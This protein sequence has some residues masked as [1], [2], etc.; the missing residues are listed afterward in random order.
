MNPFNKNTVG[1]L[2]PFTNY[3]YIILKFQGDYFNKLFVNS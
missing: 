1:L 3:K 2:S